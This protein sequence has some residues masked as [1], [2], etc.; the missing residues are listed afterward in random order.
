MYFAGSE[1]TVL[2]KMRESV[3]ALY[4]ETTQDKDKILEKYLNSIYF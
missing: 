3:G 2:E 1:R 4:T